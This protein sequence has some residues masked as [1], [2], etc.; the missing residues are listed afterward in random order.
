MSIKNRPI[1]YRAVFLFAIVGVFLILCV[2]Q[3]LQ[4]TFA[5]F[6]FL[7]CSTVVC[8]VCL[9]AVILVSHFRFP[10]NWIITVIVCQ[11]I[12]DSIL[13]LIF[14]IEKKCSQITEYNGG[15]NATGT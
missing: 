11:F 2:G 7:V 1:G 3:S 15:R 9:I 14:W 13:R 5:L 4:L 6:V 8:V 12:C 10:P